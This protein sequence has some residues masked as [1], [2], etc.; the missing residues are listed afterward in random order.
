[1]NIDPQWK[2]WAS[3]AQARYLDAVEKY[4]SPTKAARELG[5]H[6]KTVQVAVDRAERRAVRAGYAPEYG[7]HHP[8]PPGRFVRNTTVHFGKDGEVLNS[9]VRFPVEDEEWLQNV[10][11]AMSE[12]AADVGPIVDVPA[13]P[14][15]F[16]KDII[17]W[18]QIGDAHF[19]MLAHCWETGQNFDLKIAEA[20]MRAAFGQLID[21]LPSCERLVI[22]DL[23]DFTHYE[24]MGGVTDASGHALDYDGRFPKMIKVY[25]R[26]MRWMVEKALTKAKHVD[27]IVNQ[28]NHSRTNDMWMAELLDVAYGATGRVHV[29][30]NDSVFIGYRMGNTLVMTHHSDKCRPNKLC[31]VMITDFREDYGQTEF[32]YIDIGH[33][34]HKQQVKEHAGITIESFNNLAPMD[35]YAHDGGWRSRQSISYVLRSRKYGEVGRRTLPI[36]EIHDRMQR[37]G[38]TVQPFRKRAFVA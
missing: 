36:Q 29:L 28:G 10:R 4:G 12:F 2:R 38:S 32:H 35:K 24:N 14:L 18:I 30:N 15:D 25:S 20:E 16:D 6:K 5:V 17:P 11:E 1:M 34:H 3:P 19:G 21:E 23:G 22:N 27:V 9:W 7:L 37:A 31:D 8:A 13:A 26:T 33:V